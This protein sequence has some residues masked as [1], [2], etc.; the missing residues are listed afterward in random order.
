M[1]KAIVFDCF[2]VLAGDGWLPFKRKHF[3]HDPELFERAGD[4]NKLVDSGLAD[5]DEFVRDVARMANVPEAE[6]RQQIEANPPNTELF[7][8]IASELKPHYKIG[9][10]SNAAANWLPE[11]FTEGQNALFDAVALSYEMGVIKPQPEAYYTIAERLGVETAECV[12]VDDQ[13]R[14]CTSARE[15]GMQVVIF[16]SFEQCKSDLEKI[17]A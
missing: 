7:D 2:G 15:A 16:R 1:I 14:Y 4:L 8:Y 6:A 13:E 10:L 3:G 9:L 5:Y 17:I 11:L 12:L